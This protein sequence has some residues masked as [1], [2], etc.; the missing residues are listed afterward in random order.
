MINHVK[1]LG[2]DDDKDIIDVLD[3]IF[4]LNPKT[5]PRYEL[6][7]DVQGFLK[8]LSPDVHICIVDYY[9]KG[10]SGLELIQ[11]VAKINT[12]C[13]FIMISGQNDM[14]VVINLMNSSYGCRYIKKG[15]ANL[16]KELLYHITDILKRINTIE[17]FFYEAYKNKE[18]RGK[19]KDSINDL[20]D[21]L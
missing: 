7:T 20:K 14:D 15:D 2:I 8:A 9:L 19:L 6:F 21:T 12:Y 5:V 1:L 10:T 11:K 17:S 16:M 4:K 3:M 13:F 18:L